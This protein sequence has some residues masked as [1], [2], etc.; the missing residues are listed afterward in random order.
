MTSHRWSAGGRAPWGPGDRQVS[1]AVG[2]ELS[3]HEEWS[4]WGC[5]EAGALG[6]AAP[7]TGPL[8]MPRQA[9]GRARRA[10]PGSGGEGCG[11]DA[12]AQGPSLQWSR[13]RDRHRTTQRHVLTGHTVSTLTFS[14]HHG[15]CSRPAS[16]PFPDPRPQRLA[17]ASRAIVLWPE[18]RWL[19]GSLTRRPAP[20]AQGARGS[21]WQLGGFPQALGLTG[22][23]LLSCEASV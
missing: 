19:S 8:P 1:L 15:P 11:L 23:M 2:E 14:G 13:H 17:S 3:K 16:S 21:V 22:F 7:L 12:G 5:T 9:V 20:R 10:R 4:S 6:D 18:A